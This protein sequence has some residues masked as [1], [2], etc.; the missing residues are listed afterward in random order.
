ME[1]QRTTLCLLYCTLPIRLS[2]KYSKSNCNSNKTYFFQEIR[3]TKMDVTVSPST[4]A[5]VVQLTGAYGPYAVRGTNIIIR[6][7][8]CV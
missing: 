3:E 5:Y 1:E 6:E 8:S 4:R 2:A 7:E